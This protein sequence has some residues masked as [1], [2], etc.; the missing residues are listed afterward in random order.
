[1]HSRPR[2]CSL[3]SCIA[4]AALI[5]GS[6]AVADTP[7]A[8][9]GNGPVLPLLPIL[10]CPAPASA[11]KAHVAA[12]PLPRAGRGD[13]TIRITSD[14]AVISV[15][16]DA[17]LKGNVQ[18][19]QGDRELS[20]DEVDYAADRKSF[21]VRGHVQYSDPVLRAS[22]G[23]GSYGATSGSNF[24]GAEF[25]LPERPARG[26][27]KAMSLDTNGV[28]TL[29]GVSFSTCPSST[30]DWRLRASS[31]VLDTRAGVGVGR[32]ATIDFKG[33]PLLYLPWM[34][35]PLGSERKSGFL[36][37][38][39]GH[40]SRT[41][42][43]LSA[44]Y[45]WN[46]AAQYDLTVDPSIFTSRGLNV[47]SEF[48]FLSAAQNGRL[49]VDFLPHDRLA[50]F[51][52]QSDPNRSRVH[53]DD[54]AQ[55]TNG[56]RLHIDAENV[57]D[58]AWYEDFAQGPEGT[59]VPF[60]KR[61]AEVTYRDENW[62][63]R[64]EIQQFQT[65]DT[66]LLATDRPY[67]RMPGVEA[68]GDWHGGQNSA[69]AWGFD[70]E[71][72]DFQR[73]QGVQ[74][75]RADIAPRIGLDFS[76]PGY[77]LRPTVGYRFTRYALSDTAPGSNDSPQRSLPFAML[78]AGLAFERAADAGGQRRVTLEPRLLY[79][80]TPY[81][82]QSALPVFDT[83]VP[84]LNL[85]QL[86]R[87]NRYVGADRVSDANQLSVGVTSRLFSSTTGAQFLAATIGQTLY[88]E[89]PRVRL[90]DES[91]VSRHSSDLIAQLSLTGFKNWNA[92]LGLQWNPNSSR[93][94]T[95]LV[96]LQYRP[97][98][99]H[100]IN[101]GYRFQRG[102]IQQADVSGAWPI[103]QRWNLFARAVYD[104]QE[105]TLLDKFLGLE[106]KACCWRLRLVARRFVSSR[107]GATDTPI[108]LQLELNGLASVGVPADAFLESAIRGYS[109]PAT[110][111]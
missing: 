14:D 62:R 40:G 18:L 10:R 87:N 45:Y 58:K 23:S 38:N 32:G 44:P 53:L 99:E 70:S 27:A 93:S 69:L 2:R 31:I 11:T 88:F 26:T 61:L 83:A 110:D 8:D 42:F 107:T 90:P 109:A 64:G 103:G 36:F 46:I 33:V 56:W 111:R 101:V 34:S 30:P 54:L 63:L 91:A 74:G 94:E 85:V 102:L 67:S 72:V 48:R 60:V 92:D 13:D 51:S 50:S 86:Y 41:G 59:S 47:S 81:R 29:S 21:T 57:S 100:G 98:S 89:T 17:Q 104:L 19:R 25:E 22:G 68:Q 97:D 52:S 43:L 7:P 55:L 3:S 80:Y 105:N 35:F 24:V 37:P 28:A 75:W 71:I 9:P 49:A 95:S 66:G 106:Y 4:V 84:D 78:D 77:F 15:Q 82:D 79:L 65:I 96:K 1:M 20:A 5:G 108:Y 76:K 12:K 6:V 16:G 73:S 39:F